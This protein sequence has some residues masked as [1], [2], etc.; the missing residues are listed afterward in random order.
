ML[1]TPSY[2]QLVPHSTLLC[3]LSLQHGLTS[4]Q[5]YFRNLHQLKTS[6][7]RFEHVVEPPTQGQIL[8]ADTHTLSGT[9]HQVTEADVCRVFKCVKSGKAAGPDGITP[10]VLKSCYGQVSFVFTDIF[11][12][13]LSLCVVTTCFKKSI[14]VPVPKKSPASCLNDFRPVALTS[15]IMKCFEQPVKAYINNNISANIDPL[16]FAYRS[17]RAVDDAVSLALYT[18]LKHLEGKTHTVEEIS[19]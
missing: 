2:I 10:R 12:L 17:N 4:I 3:P 19:I 15:V 9:T 18:V 8:A 11:N 5:Q 14:I 16:Q 7:A 6:Y 1:M 13:S